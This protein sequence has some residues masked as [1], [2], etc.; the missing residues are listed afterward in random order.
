M[1]SWAERELQEPLKEYET[2]YAQYKKLE[3][4][5][6]TLTQNQQQRARE[7]DILEF[8]IGELSAL[9]LKENEE[10]ELES[11]ISA[12]ENGERINEVLAS[13]HRQLIQ[14]S[15]SARDRLHICARDLEGI[16]QYTPELETLCAEISDMAYRLDDI[17]AEVD[18]F[19]DQMEYDEHEL[20]RLNDRLYEI[21][22]ICTKY[23]C[24]SQQLMEFE[25]SA[26][27]KLAG[28]Q[29]S[30]EKFGQVEKELKRL[31]G[32]LGKAAKELHQIRER[33]AAIFAKEMERQLA[34][35]NM[36][37]AKFTVRFE[38]VERYA[39]NGTDQVE[40]LISPNPGEE[41]KPLAKIASGGELSRI[42]LSLKSI[43]SAYDTV[44]TY[45]FD[46]IDTGI[47]GRTAEKVAEKLRKVAISN[48]TLIIT[49]SPHIAA[50]ADRHYLIQKAVNGGVTKTS[51]K[52][53]DHKGRIEEIAR[54]NSGS[55]IS[56]AAIAQAAEL[57]KERSE[58]EQKE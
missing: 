41:V 27:E 54:I 55:H 1:D 57:L 32:L 9:H 14:D 31:D 2:L 10:E 28:L 3:T 49:H 34:D 11:R 51:L 20:D 5:H 33:E 52:L 50:I 42:M 46:E 29:E 13:V 58:K 53:L 7:I 23:R 15:E 43:I 17:G 35:L 4:E 6:R 40:F 39:P 12:M 37:G 18:N 25:N 24:G 38:T 19:K 44:E 36:P 22:R 45:I 21:K 30:S 16:A 56:D 26:R 8:Q 47:S 48:Q